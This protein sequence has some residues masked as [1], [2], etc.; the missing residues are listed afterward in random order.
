[1]PPN[2]AL[3]ASVANQLLEATATT[4]TQVSEQVLAQLV[5]HFNL[6]YGFLR[7][8]D[9]DIRAS[10]LVAEWPPR[11]DVPDPDPLAVVQFTSSDPVFALGEHG[12]EPIV[13]EPD[14]VERAHDHWIA[15]RRQAA[16][17]RW[18]SRPCSRGR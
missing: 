7:H 13:I 12:K 14:Q 8:S 5:D 10:V 4:A 6:D 9:H 18:P 2:L 17:P 11:P 16:W 1:M 3:V 15:G